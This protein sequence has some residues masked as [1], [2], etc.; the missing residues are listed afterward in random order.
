MAKKYMHL[1]VD[2]SWIMTWE[3]NDTGNGDN[4]N[5]HED[6]GDSD[7]YLNFNSVIYITCFTSQ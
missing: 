4:V 7:I 3:S 6:V 2:L 1:M 5:F